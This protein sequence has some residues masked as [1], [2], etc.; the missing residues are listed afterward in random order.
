MS[1]I[2]SSKALSLWNMADFPPVLQ[3]QSSLFLAVS[4]SE[5]KVQ[6]SC[7]STGAMSLAF[8]K[9]FWTYGPVFTGLFQSTLQPELIWVCFY[10]R[11]PMPLCCFLE[12][13]ESGTFFCLLS[14]S[15][16]CYCLHESFW[17]NSYWICYV[18]VLHSSSVELCRFVFFQ[19][20]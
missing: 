9:M 15:C 8:F 3:T 4:W 16:F 2:C 1:G 20:W 13:W 11:F 5:L 17:F 10:P 6:L 18:W 14:P 7:S 12:V 19:Q